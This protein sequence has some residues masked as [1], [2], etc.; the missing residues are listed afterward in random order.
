MS[1]DHLVVVLRNG[2]AARVMDC[3]VKGCG[4][5][6]QQGHLMELPHVPELWTSRGDYRE[7]RATHPLDIIGITFGDGKLHLIK[8]QGEKAPLEKGLFA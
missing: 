4:P 3:D 6:T 2:K 1:A 8:E 7:D 5:F